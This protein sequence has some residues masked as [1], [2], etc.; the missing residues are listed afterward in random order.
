MQQRADP[1]EVAGQSG[2]EHTAAQDVTDLAGSTDER[3]LFGDPRPQPS[4]HTAPD[5]GGIPGQRPPNGGQLVGRVVEDGTPDE[6]IGGGGRFARL[7][8][9]WKDSLV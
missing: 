6:L 7:H 8:G 3:L 2:G 9:A 1:H 5:I 4:Q